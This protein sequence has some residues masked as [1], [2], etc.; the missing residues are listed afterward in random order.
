MLFRVKST[1][2]EEITMTMEEV[3]IEE[4]EE[5]EESKMITEIMVK[6]HAS[7]IKSP[8]PT[9]SSVARSISVTLERVVNKDVLLIDGLEKAELYRSSYTGEYFV[10]L[11]SHSVVSKT[12]SHI[13]YTTNPITSVYN[14][15]ERI[16]PDRNT[17]LAAPNWELD[18]VMGPFICKEEAIDCSRA[19]VNGTRGKVSKREKA[20]YL[21]RAYNVN[22]YTYKKKSE[23][24]LEELLRENADP[25]F[26]ELLERE[27]A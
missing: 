5:D 16:F 17:S 4:E 11:M 20:P 13:G 15:N 10:F 2:D 14:H 27:R 6:R 25:L 8:I 22:M 19:W 24:P 23:R 12:D 3:E 21:S 9:R 18:I 1:L 26:I 7:F